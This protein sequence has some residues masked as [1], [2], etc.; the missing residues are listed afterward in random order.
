L[1]YGHCDDRGALDMLAA[2]CSPGCLR[3]SQRRT[4]A[5]LAPTPFAFISG[6]GHQDFLDTV[7]HL[8]RCVTPE[9]VESTLFHPWTY[10][11]EGL[12]LRWDPVEDRRHALMDRDPTADDNKPRTVWMANLLAYRALVLFPSVPTQHGLETVGW[13]RDNYNNWVFTWPL[14]D[15]P[16]EPDSIRSLLLLS[17]LYL[18]KPDR[19]S[20]QARGVRDVFRS[21][22]IKVGS[23]GHVKFNFTPGREV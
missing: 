2:F 13:M 10:E 8:M 18:P 12:S 15:H 19:V 14:W 6:S 4:E 9:R 1:Q 20:L 7:R 11:D 5:K 17:D 3:G 21:V 23:A 22:R 16:L